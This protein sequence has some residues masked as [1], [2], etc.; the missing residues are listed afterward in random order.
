V[1]SCRVGDQWVRL[2]A[3]GEIVLG[4]YDLE[5]KKLEPARAAGLLKLLQGVA[6][7][8]RPESRLVPG[9][10]FGRPGCDFEKWYLPDEAALVRLTVGLEGRPEALR[11]LH[12]ALGAAV[13]AALGASVRQEFDDRAAPF[14]KPDESED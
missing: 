13:E 9:A 3:G 11:S 10:Y 12:E 6:A 4:H 14:A 8:E 7:P 1:R 2:T 5:R